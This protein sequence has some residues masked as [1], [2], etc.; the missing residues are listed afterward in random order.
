MMAL[1][2]GA[3]VGGRQRV[4]DNER[5][6]VAQLV[7]RFAR[8]QAEYRAGKYNETETRREF[9]DPLFA[10]LGW[11]VDN[12]GGLP[13]AYKEVIHEDA[14]QIGGAHKAP[15]YAFRIG[16]QRKFFVEAKKPSVNL[17]LDPT[18]AFQLRRY[19]WSAQ[20]PVGVLTDFE[21]FAVYDGF[22]RPDKTD[23]AAV[24]RRSHI[25]YEQYV[26]RWDE[27]AA[28]FS[29]EAVMGGALERLVPKRGTST[30]DAAFLK[31]IEWGR[32]LVARDIARHNAGLSQRELNYAVQMTIDRVIFLRM[33]EDRGIEQYGR[34][35]ALCEGG[36]VYARLRDLFRQADER[37]NSG[38]FHFQKETGHAEGPDDLTPGLTLSDRA[39]KT[40]FK[41]LYYPDS[42]YEFAVLPVEVLGQVYEQFLG[43]V[44]QLH[45]SR[46]EIEEK[47][48]VRKA[49][50]VYYTPK[51][52]V[53]Y[54]VRQTLDPLL[55]GKTPRQ[56]EALKVVDPA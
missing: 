28:L 14:I 37:Y 8:N 44:I 10:A 42:P 30:I 41:N 5:E 4:A 46:V 56:A 49:G 15:D 31:Y 19:A 32:V 45:G 47:P 55:A 16:G 36:E 35:R 51:Y 50:G 39:L 1:A 48:E 3:R 22:E 21:E 34:L 38:L 26:E 6:R 24:A 23:S 33:A 17:A 27:L 25:T 52:I 12:A 29:R 2:G 20:L 9:I 54:I 18:P 7:E 40:I 13:E 43:R 53:D 11:D